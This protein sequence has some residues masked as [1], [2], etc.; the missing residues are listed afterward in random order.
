MGGVSRRNLKMFRHLIGSDS[1]KNVLIVTTMWDSVDDNVGGRREE[2]L[3]SGDTPFKPL[4]D[5]GARVVRHDLGSESASR[6][7]ET[8]LEN[9]PK[10]LLIQ[11]ELSN[12]ISLAKTS[13][14]AEL[15]ADLDQFVERDR[16]KLRDLQEEL[17][18]AIEEGDMELVEE[19]K[20]ELAKLKRRISSREE[21]KEKL[22][23][24]Y[25]THGVVGALIQHHATTARGTKRAGGVGIIG[26]M[27]GV[28][29]LTL[30]RVVE[31][32][33]GAPGDSQV[34]ISARDS[35]LGEITGPQRGECAARRKCVERLRTFA[36]VA[37]GAAVALTVNAKVRTQ[38]FEDLQNMCDT[39]VQFLITTLRILGLKI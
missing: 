37:I 25:G 38:I 4:V 39:L 7:I 16:R 21:D 17:D 3:K 32:C 15:S 36:W 8:L 31:M 26:G 30:R 10:E 23:T 14:G 12:G 35:S 33:V 34:Q 27:T 28:G 1:L 6:I 20:R 2:E 19:L 29:L 18:D 13:A 11:T 5:A 22:A 24:T 9:V